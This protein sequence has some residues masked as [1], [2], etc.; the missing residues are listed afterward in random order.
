M[1]LR[2]SRNLLFLTEIILAI[3]VFAVCAVIC[4]SLLLQAERISEQS[5]DLTQAVFL[6]QNA[7]EVAR[8][9]DNLLTVAEILGG[10]LVDSLIVVFYDDN[11]QRVLELELAK[12][13]LQLEIVDGPFLREIIVEVAAAE[14]IYSLRSTVLR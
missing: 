4:V 1:R 9:A 2:R 11:W 7:V 8:L 12:Y 10:S 14:P 13:R 3:A 6:A 5:S